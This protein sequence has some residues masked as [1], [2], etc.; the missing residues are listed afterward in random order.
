M[1]DATQSLKTISGQIFAT[2]PASVHTVVQ[3]INQYIDSF[4]GIVLFLVIFG[5]TVWAAGFILSSLSRGSATNAERLFPI[6]AASGMTALFFLLA[7]ILHKALAFSISIDST[8]MAA[9]VLAAALFAVPLTI[10]NYAPRRKLEIEKRS[11]IVAAKAQ[12]RLTKLKVVEDLLNKAKSTI[13]INVR[14]LDGKEAVTKDKLDEILTRASAR[15][16]KLPELDKKS[17]DLDGELSTN[18]TGLSTELDEILAK[19]QLASN[20][21]YSALVRNLTEL[22]YEVKNPLTLGFQKDQPTEERIE[23]IRQVLDA[24]RLLGVEVNQLSERIY[25]VLASLYDPS[26]PAE[27]PTLIF[28]RQKLEEKTAPW[29][30]TD[31]LIV[32]LNSWKRNY[33]SEISKSIEALKKSLVYLIKLSAQGKTLSIVI[34]DKNS[35]IMDRLK[36]AEEIR[37]SIGKQPI[38][39]LNVTIAKDAFSSSFAIT[40]EVL[41]IIYEELKNK[42]QSIESL[43]PI[44]DYFWEKNITLEE[45]MSSEIEII[46]NS[47]KYTLNKGMESLPLAQ[48]LIDQGIATVAVYNEKNELL[49]NYPVA[50]TVIEDLIRQK[51][52][53]SVEDLPFEPKDA[54]KYLRLFQYQRY[55]EFSFD[56]KD[57]QLTR[58]V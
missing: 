52:R 8:T 11:M 7:T 22:G 4:P 32:A 27:S 49:L 58:K 1:F 2:P 38:N 21:Q 47:S 6:V 34:G 20:Y 53:I 30:A 24:G 5:G 13:P 43:Q 28:V 33:S 35:E 12:D 29:I 23:T 50:K 17:D 36:E 25:N 10:A 3:A 51:K 39:L 19:Y 42:E 26:L 57:L 37:K 18:L 46:S 55:R 41:S 9:G 44:T 16:Y 45:E 15:S 31:A 54:E 48:S 14:S 40:K 56:E